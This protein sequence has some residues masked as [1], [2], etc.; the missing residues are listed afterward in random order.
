[1]KTRNIKWKSPM[2]AFSVFL[3][4]ILVL[5]I[6]F[7]YLSLSS[8]V[9][10]INMKEFAS[11]RNTYSKILYSKRGSIYDADG[12]TLATDVSSYTVI[13]YLDESRTG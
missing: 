13:A 5:F 9:Y 3:V 2:I 8:N 10:G 7:L 6:Q 12:N 11:N 1:M 4:F